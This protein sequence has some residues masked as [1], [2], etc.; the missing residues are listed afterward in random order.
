MLISCFYRPKRDE[1]LKHCR[2]LVRK[3]RYEEMTR[4]DPFKAMQYLRHHIAAVIDHSDAEQLNNV[5]FIFLSACF[6]L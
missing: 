3:M 2:F 1:I 6:S 5:C 4:Q